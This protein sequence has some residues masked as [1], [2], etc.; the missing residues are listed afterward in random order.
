MYNLSTISWT[1]NGLMSE[2]TYVYDD[3]NWKDK[4]MS[5]NGTTFTYDE[6][7]NPENYRDGMVFEWISRILIAKTMNR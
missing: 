2:K 5:Y 6:V 3:T 1:P 7:G 4:L